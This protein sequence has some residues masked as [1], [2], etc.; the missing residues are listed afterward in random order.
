M[1][2][3]MKKVCVFLGSSI[4]KNDNF[5]HQTKE[6]A[7]QLVNHDIELI[8]GAAKIGLMGEL[9]DTILKY[10][11]K[12]T[13]VIPRGLL[14]KEIVHEELSELII[15]SSMHERKMYMSNLASGFI[16][17][18]GG[19]GTLEE[20]SEVL[21]WAQLG[22]HSKP[23]GLLNTGNFYQHLLKQLDLMVNQNFLSPEHRNLLLVHEKPSELLKLLKKYQAPNFQIWM[24]ENE[25]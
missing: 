18:P 24:N 7:K 23:C 8:Y 15:V 1:V 17:L 6:L 10:G 2:N 9:A 16:A 3:F 21:T 11:G 25:V 12:V 22:I 14:H 4:G 19:F 13:G 20:I 5:S